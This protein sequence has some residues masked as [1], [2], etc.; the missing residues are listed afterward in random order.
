MS[1]VLQD[2][3][4]FKKLATDS[5][6]AADELVVD[7]FA[8]GGGASTGLEQAI[9]RAVDVAIN[10]N[11]DAVAMHALN[12]AMTQHYCEDVWAVD[13]LKAV[14]EGRVGWMHASPVGQPA[15]DARDRARQP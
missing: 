13:P 3:F 11:P 7:L 12:H 8:G 2:G 5:R 4:A 10:H 9:G 1:A 15:P 14:P 6:L